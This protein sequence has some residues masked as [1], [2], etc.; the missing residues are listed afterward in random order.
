MERPDHLPAQ[1]HPGGA[2]KSYGI[3]VARLAGVPKEI[4]DRAKDI[5]AHL[6]KPNG[7][8]ETS[9]ASEG[10]AN[11]KGGQRARET[12]AGFILTVRPRA[13]ARRNKGA[14][15]HARVKA[16]WLI[17]RLRERNA[18]GLSKSKVVRNAASD[19][20]NHGRCN[21]RASAAAHSGV[22]N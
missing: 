1:D 15:D 13:S 6:E 10:P 20:A 12:A 9:K 7:A 2:D 14:G 4:L 8:V 3:H 11:E 22:A 5:L 17:K 19:E 21:L 16:F 18:T